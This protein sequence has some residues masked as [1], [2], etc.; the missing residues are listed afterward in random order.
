MNDENPGNETADEQITKHKTLIVYNARPMLKGTVFTVVLAI[1][2]G[3]VLLPFFVPSPPLWAY[4]GSALSALV[5]VIYASILERTA[6]K[7]FNLKE[8][9]RVNLIIRDMQA[10]QVA[11]SEGEIKNENPEDKGTSE[12]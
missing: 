4:I 1:Y 6:S 7:L 10:S 9:F 11:D 5:W 3:A 8:L 12:S 2:A